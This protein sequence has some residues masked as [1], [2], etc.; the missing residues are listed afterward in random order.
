MT[1]REHGRNSEVRIATG[2]AQALIPVERGGF[3]R[4]DRATPRIDTQNCRRL[5]RS[6]RRRGDS[7][8]ESVRRSRDWS[9]RGESE[10]EI[11]AR[12]MSS[13]MEPEINWGLGRVRR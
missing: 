2:F 8:S 13:V 11:V 10:R 7:D 4:M 9:V 6:A 12:P 1:G 3:M 5:M